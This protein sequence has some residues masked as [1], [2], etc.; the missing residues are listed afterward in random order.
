MSDKA[1]EVSM[2]ATTHDALH[3]EPTKHHAGAVLLPVPER[4][5]KLWNIAMCLF[6]TI[7][8]AATL[9]VGDLDLRVPVYGSE[10][11]LITLVNNSDAWQYI[12]ATPAR[13][14]SWLYLTWLTACF[15]LLSALAHLGNAL[16]WRKYY[17]EALS[18]GYAPFR[19]L[20]YTFSASV[21]MLLLA[22]VSGSIVLNTLVLL[23][24]LT[25]VTMAF[26]HLHEVIC[27]PSSLDEWSISNKLLRLQAH[28]IGYVP[29]CFA[30]G[31]IIAQFIDAGGQSTIDE[32]GDK[33]QMPDFVYAIVFGEVIIFWC[34]GIVQLI[35]SLR[36]PAK[37]Y[38]G[39]IA[40]MYL[41]LFAK[42]FLGILVLS[43]VLM[44]ED[45]Q[46][47]YEAS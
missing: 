11:E 1:P 8:A 42:G 35:V 13:R 16:L 7:L 46:E 5:L 34:F 47:L 39:E 15:F 17:V 10:L 3:I 31:V 36:P 32:D 26:G 25:A 24:G 33:R 44:V 4:Q 40:Y 23:F 18:H 2:T 37:Y 29:Q 45:N 19:W 9:G 12:P 38:Q 21:M 27:R 22:Y 6:H 43:N 14:T 30:W 41:S 20:E 28:F